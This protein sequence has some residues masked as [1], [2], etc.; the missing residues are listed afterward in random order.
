[1]VAS[2]PSTNREPWNRGK[3]VGRKAPLKLKE[4]WA[5]RVRLQLQHRARDLALFNLGIDSTLRAC[6]LVRLRVRDVC[7]EI[8]LD[9]SALVFFSGILEPR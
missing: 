3:P 1:M 4:I 8:G 7:Q 9:P 5:I 2:T 6:D